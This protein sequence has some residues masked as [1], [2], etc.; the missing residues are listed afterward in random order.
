MMELFT[1]A[2]ATK[3]TDTIETMLPAMGLLIRSKL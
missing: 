3:T 1:S 2:L